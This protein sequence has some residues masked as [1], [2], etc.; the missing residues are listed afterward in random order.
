MN[1][2][3]ATRIVDMELR[4]R[5][6]ASR[7]SQVDAFRLDDELFAIIMGQLN[8]VLSVTPPYLRGKLSV[9]SFVMA[10]AA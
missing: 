4:S 7:V 6:E 9:S 10:T 5:G 2:S 1:A 3:W 8:Q